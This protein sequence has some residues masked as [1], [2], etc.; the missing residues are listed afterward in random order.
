MHRRQQAGRMFIGQKTPLFAE[1]FLIRNCSLCVY[2]HTSQGKQIHIMRIRW[3]WIILRL[4]IKGWTQRMCLDI[5]V[6]IVR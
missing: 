2:V 4:C 5:V 6:H 1:H 3:A